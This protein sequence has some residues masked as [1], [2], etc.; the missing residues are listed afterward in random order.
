MTMRCS[1]LL[2][3]AFVF[4]A[5]SHAQG[6]TVQ[7]KRKIGPNVM[8]DVQKAQATHMYLS[9]LHNYC[10]KQ[11]LDLQSP[12][13]MNMQVQDYE[14]QISQPQIQRYRLFIDDSCVPH[15]P[16]TACANNAMLVTAFEGS[17]LDRFAVFECEKGIHCT[18]AGK[19]SVPLR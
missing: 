4:S 5:I 6:P 18:A 2:A 12:E 9:Y 15:E 19:C 1:A 13:Q 7:Y 17:F 8:T 14:H 10:P 11:R 3:A 16:A